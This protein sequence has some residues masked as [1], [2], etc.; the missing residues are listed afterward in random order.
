MAGRFNRKHRGRSWMQNVIAGA[1]T[2]G[3][4]EIAAE[5]IDSDH[6]VDGS[7][8]TAHIA[9]DAVTTALMTL[10]LPVTLCIPTTLANR[11]GSASDGVLVGALT[12]EAVQ[13]AF[14]DDGGAFTDETTEANSA[15]AND[16]TLLPAVETTSDHYY[17]GMDDVF[18]GLKLTIGTQGVSGGGGAAAITWEYW[19]GAAFVTL[20][21]SQFLDDSVGFTAA[22]GT[23]FTTWTIPADWA[24]TE[25]NSQSAFWVR[26]RCAVADYTTTPIGTQCW[27]L[28]PD[29]GQGVRMPF[30]G[31]IS[32]I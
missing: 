32:A 18:C 11:G 30:A 5:S 29:V 27:I 13:F 25:I 20:E 15:G 19:S 24:A 3:G 4:T 2:I 8:D 26:A 16:M 12:P 7:I 22:P 6:Y 28:S 10:T 23:Y 9:N 17:F 31:T 21:T 14:A 1:S